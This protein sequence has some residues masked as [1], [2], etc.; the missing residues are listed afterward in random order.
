MLDKQDVYYECFQVEQS[1]SP[2][3]TADQLTG[4]KKVPKILNKWLGKLT[5][6]LYWSLI[7]LLTTV[8]SPDQVKSQSLH[9]TAIDLETE[10]EGNSSR[11][12]HQVAGLWLNSWPPGMN[13]DDQF[14][15]MKQSQLFEKAHHLCGLCNN[16]DQSPSQIKSDYSDFV[17]LEECPRCGHSIN[18]TRNLMS[19]SS[20]G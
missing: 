18:F 19:V 5:G 11:N 17:D 20:V 2:A 6:H 1:E 7:C 9:Q 8:S 12:D 4:A 3:S 10:T 15:R 13:Q 14:E 16:L